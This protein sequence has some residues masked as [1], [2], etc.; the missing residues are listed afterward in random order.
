VDRGDATLMSYTLKYISLSDVDRLR[1]T[2]SGRYGLRSLFLFSLRYVSLVITQKNTRG[3]KEIK[4][5]VE[6]REQEKKNRGSK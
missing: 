3:G 6:L 1:Q 5:K 2:M 4:K